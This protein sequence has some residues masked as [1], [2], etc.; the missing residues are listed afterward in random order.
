MPRAASPAESRSSPNRPPA[1]VRPVKAVAGLVLRED[2]P[3][4]EV[5]EPAAV[6]LGFGEH[7][8]GNSQ[9]LLIQSPHRFANA[10]SSRYVVWLRFIW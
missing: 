3:Q 5:G 6:R 10:H 1:G 9:K 7:G 2:L 4:A 8:L